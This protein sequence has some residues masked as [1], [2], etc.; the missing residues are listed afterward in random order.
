MYI[1]MDDK[2]PLLHKSNR[3]LKAMSFIESRQD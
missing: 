3:F 2:G 1:I